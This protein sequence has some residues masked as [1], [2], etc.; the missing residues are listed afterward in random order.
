M[1]TTDEIHVEIK[2]C[3]NRVRERRQEPADTACP[4]KAGQKIKWD[5]AHGV[6]RRGVVTRVFCTG[7]P[8]WEMMVDPILVSGKTGLPVRVQRYNSPE[9]D[10]CDGVDDE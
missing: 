5:G 4:F 9:P 1:R 6:I 8:A 2:A 3:E 10:D 7:Y